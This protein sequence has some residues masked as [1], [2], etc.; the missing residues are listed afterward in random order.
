M[1]NV[2]LVIRQELKQV[3]IQGGPI[4]ANILPFTSVATVNNQLTFQLLNVQGLPITFSQIICIFIMGI[5]QN[6]LTSD[7]VI[8]NTS[9]GTMV[10]FSQGISLG[11]TVYGAGQI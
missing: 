8:T 6:I 10:T 3:V 7:Y 11:Y 9:S 2:Q 1:N 5:G 4:V